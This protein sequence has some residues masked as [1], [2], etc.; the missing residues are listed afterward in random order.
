MDFDTPKVSVVLRNQND[1]RA[2]YDNIKTAAKAR[3]VWDYINPELMIQP[4]EPQMPKK[5]GFERVKTG[6]TVVF[7][8]RTTKNGGVY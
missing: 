8:R 1:W 6:V 5:P 4:F 7:L 2:W 3:L